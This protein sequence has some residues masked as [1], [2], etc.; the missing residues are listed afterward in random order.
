MKLFRWSAAAGAA[1]LAVS[2]LAHAASSSG[3][4]TTA[5]A[6]PSAA[7]HATANGLAGPNASPPVATPA[8]PNDQLFYA[9]G[10]LLSQ[11]LGT[12]NLSE[13][14]FRQVLK[15]FTDG[16]RHHAKLEDAQKLV[17]ALQNV[18]RERGQVLMQRQKA[19]GAA[20]LAKVAMLHGAH[21][22]ASGL[23]F[24]NTVPGT[25]PAPKAT[26]QVK[27]QYTGKLIDGTTFDSSLS[28]GEPATFPLAGI[29]P[30]W[31]EALQLMKVG[32]K[33][34]VVCPSDLAY[35][36]RGRPP[37]IPP[38][39]TLDFQVELLAVMPAPAGPPRPILPGPAGL[40]PRP[41]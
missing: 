31:R 22:T 27:V 37:V 12:F 20:L 6:V 1:I 10:V 39:A 25:G 17:P 8:A 5:P 21:K 33:A 23:V 11:N 15:G 4:A 24:V 41:K 7:A 38:G 18:E 3:P 13:Q 35:G 9:L 2:L 14:E 32:G 30:C 36:D 34:R 29:I 26:D 19:A 16:F 40:P 28:R